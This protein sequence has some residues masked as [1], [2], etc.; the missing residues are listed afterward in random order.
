M[1][2]TRLPNR[3]APENAA[4]YLTGIRLLDAEPVIDAASV[5]IESRLAQ[6]LPSRICDGIQGPGLRVKPGDH[7]HLVGS[8]GCAGED[9]VENPVLPRTASPVAQ[10]F[11]IRFR[12]HGRAA[13]LSRES[14]CRAPR[15]AAVRGHHRVSVIKT[16]GLTLG[17]IA[18]IEP[19]HAKRTG[20]GR[21]AGNARFKLI[22]S[23]AGIRWRHIQSDGGTPGGARIRT[24]PI[25][26][27]DLI[28]AVTR[29]DCTELR[30]R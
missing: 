9:I 3:R 17:R 24:R 8:V 5:V 1:P 23:S 6:A 4:G 22:A 11:T 19:G 27:L 14:V 30:T 26:D 12:F 29:V 13:T 10:V 20:V 15:G 2:L 25:V 18:R 7:G 28:S 16:I 21:R